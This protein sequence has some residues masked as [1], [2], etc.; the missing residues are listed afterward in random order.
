MHVQTQQ[1]FGKGFAL[2]IVLFHLQNVKPLEKGLSQVP[3]TDQTFGKGFDSGALYSFFL[4]V[5]GAGGKVILVSNKVQ[6]TFISTCL[7]FIFSSPP[8]KKI[9]YLYSIK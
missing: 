8:K 4:H 1:S 5:W 6:S 2:E 7:F 9:R 3:C